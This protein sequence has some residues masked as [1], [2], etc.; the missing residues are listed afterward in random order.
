[1][2]YAQKT[3]KNEEDYYEEKEL[4]KKLENTFGE[5]IDEIAA[6]LEHFNNK[7]LTLFYNCGLC[8]L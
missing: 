1:M 4:M 7:S 3:F 6:K 2:R 5:E 8:S